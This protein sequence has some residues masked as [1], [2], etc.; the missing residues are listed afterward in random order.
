MVRNSHQRL[1][2][3]ALKIFENLNC[4][5]AAISVQCASEEMLVGLA[6]LRISF[7]ADVW[8]VFACLRG[9]RLVW[10]S[11]A[12][13]LWQQERH[14]ARKRAAGRYHLGF[15]A[16]RASTVSLNASPPVGSRAVGPVRQEPILEADLA[17]S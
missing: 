10:Y 2:R 15:S 9:A 1:H 12:A 3:A 14:V 7:S 8:P 11:P 5:L 16:A 4:L 6:L 17:E 13:F